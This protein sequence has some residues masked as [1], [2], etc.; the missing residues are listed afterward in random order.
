MKK[1][2]KHQSEPKRK[3]LLALTGS[4]TNVQKAKN[5]AMHG[6]AHEF[7]F[8]R[9]EEKKHTDK[10]PRLQNIPAGLKIALLKRR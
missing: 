1:K 2:A 3:L 5:M 8:Y 4:K 7:G 6:D 10:I 9:S